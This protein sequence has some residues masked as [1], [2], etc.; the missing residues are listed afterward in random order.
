MASAPPASASHRYPDTGDFVY[1]R[2]DFDVIAAL[3]HAHAG[4]VMAP[5]KA[6]LVYSRFTKLLRERK[7]TSFSDYIELIRVD[8]EERRSAIEALTTNHTRFFREGH[9]FE[10]FNDDVRPHLLSKLQRRQ[11][12]RMWSAGSSSGEE[13][14]SL[15]MT[16][17]GSSRDEARHILQS[18]V[19]ILASDLA[20][21]VL[22]AAQAGSYAAKDADEIPPALRSNWTQI[23][24]DRMVVDPR[25]RALVRFRRLNLLD[26]WPMKQRFDVIFC[27][28][29]MIYFDDPTKELLLE[30]F[31][32]QLEPGGTLYIGHSERV[33]GPAT[34]CLVPV[35]QTAFR[36]ERA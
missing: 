11:R 17:L 23:I 27:R 2:A 34:H 8:S 19:A 28:N 26:P 25:L 21:H 24:G 30:R 15:T 29:V 16:L 36:K 18:E 4:I 7:L 20:Q 9:H 22:N 33:I 12:V 13:V 1:T 5:E 35:G 10:H 31:T 32:E 14:Y 3:I 6:M